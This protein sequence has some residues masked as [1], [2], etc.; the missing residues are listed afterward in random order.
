METL[1]LITK[2]REHVLYCSVIASNY[3]S[4]NGPVTV[5]ANSKKPTT[6]GTAVN[7]QTAYTCVPGYSPAGLYGAPYA[8]C[9]A[10]NAT[11]GDWAFNYGSCVC[12]SNYRKLALYLSI[13]I[14]AINWSRLCYLAIDSPISQL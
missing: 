7:Y 8:G 1:L 14:L 11:S 5:P 9:K 2:T 13:A 6:F 3:C 4:P 10:F 12:T